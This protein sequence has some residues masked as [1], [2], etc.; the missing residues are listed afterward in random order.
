[1]VLE[2]M[3]GVESTWEP[4]CGGCWIIGYHGSSK[5]RAVDMT[6]ADIAGFCKVGVQYVIDII[7]R[8]VACVLWQ[9]LIWLYYYIHFEPWVKLERCSQKSL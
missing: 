9:M 5:V 1:M 3:V 2:H 8:F 7:M 6:K 4:G